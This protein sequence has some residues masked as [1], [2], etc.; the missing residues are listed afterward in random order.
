MPEEAD[1]LMRLAQ[2]IVDLRWKNYEN[3]VSWKPEAF[4]PVA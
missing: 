4:Q 3:M 2:E 1:R